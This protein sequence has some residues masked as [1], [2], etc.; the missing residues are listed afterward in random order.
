MDTYH[1]KTREHFVLADMHYDG[2]YF[3]SKILKELKKQAKA[4]IPNPEKK[5]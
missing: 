2:V 3:D 4:I 5:N 1:K